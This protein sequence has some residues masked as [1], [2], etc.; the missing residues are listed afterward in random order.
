MVLIWLLLSTVLISVLIYYL[1]LAPIIDNLL[2]AVSNE[3]PVARSYIP[4]FGFALKWTKNPYGFLHWLHHQ[5]GNRVLVNIMS[6]RYIFLN[7]QAVFMNRI[8]K[9]STF[10]LDFLDKIT[11]NG[12]GIRMECVQNEEAKRVTVKEYH[13]FLYGQELL[14]LNH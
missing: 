11:H 7:D 3:P 12:G 14:I 5:Y 9:D 10:T 4:V 8:V 2:H 6:R 13:E 1:F